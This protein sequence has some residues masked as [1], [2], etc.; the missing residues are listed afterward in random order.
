MVIGLKQWVLGAVWTPLRLLD[1]EGVNIFRKLP[2]APF[3]VSV[4]VT[5][6]ENAR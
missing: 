4:M 1:A 5:P 3:S 6:C 2:K